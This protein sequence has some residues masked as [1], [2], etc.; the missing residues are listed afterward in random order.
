MAIEKCCC[1]IQLKAGVVVFTVLSLLGATYQLVTELLIVK[2]KSDHN[3]VDNE[4]YK[5]L[6]WVIYMD[7]VF[8]AIV[9]LGS[10]YGLFVLSQMNVYQQL[11][12]Y[13]NYLYVV[14]ALQILN[15]IAIII[16]TIQVKD[17]YLDT[18]KSYAYKKADCEDSY[19]KILPYIIGAFVAGILWQIYF[20]LVTRAYANRRHDKEEGILPRQ[21]IAGSPQRQLAVSAVPPTQQQLAVRMNPPNQFAVKG[22]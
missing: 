3:N 6:I 20:V 8:Y 19:N 12:I 15:G 16:A 10:M 5:T 4:L 17:K 9:V 7:I 13:V 2:N 18:C 14:L 22:L 1:C 11:K 21:S